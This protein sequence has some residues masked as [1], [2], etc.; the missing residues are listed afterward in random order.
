MTKA[1]LHKRF[2]ELGKRC[3]E[4]IVREKALL[5]DYSPDAI[6]AFNR[7]SITVVRCLQDRNDILIELAKL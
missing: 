1:E 2:D 4:A 6:V 5:G 7:A 3:E